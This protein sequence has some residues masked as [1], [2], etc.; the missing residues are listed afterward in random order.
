[1]RR[2]QEPFDLYSEFNRVEPSVLLP[3]VQVAFGPLVSCKL[4]DIQMLRQPLGMCAPN[5]ALS[6]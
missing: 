2:S 6:W 5:L 1:M 4:S 3:P